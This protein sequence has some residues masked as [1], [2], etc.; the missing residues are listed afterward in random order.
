M[1]YLSENFG[2]NWV[3]IKHYE[4]FGGQSALFS[5]PIWIS[6]KYR[7]SGFYFIPPSSNISFPDVETSV[8][9]WRGTDIPSFGITLHTHLAKTG[10]KIQQYLSPKK[11]FYIL[12]WQK[13][14]YNLLHDIRTSKCDVFIN[15]KKTRIS[16]KNIV[17]MCTRLAIARTCYPPFL[18]LHD[19]FYW[20]KNSGKSEK[21][22]NQKT[23][24]K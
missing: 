22:R 16:G 17:L 10:Q 21:A 8:P 5:N 14:S 2:R 7:G 9:L 1:G 19:P 11:Y 13:Y 6:H 23:T 20:N 18:S 3:Y 4:N 24:K 15:V 12:W